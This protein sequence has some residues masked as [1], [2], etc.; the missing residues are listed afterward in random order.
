[1]TRNKNIQ[2]IDQKLNGLCFLPVSMCNIILVS[3]IYGL[4]AEKI[5][6]AC[7][8]VTLLCRFLKQDVIVY[9]FILNVHCTCIINYIDVVVYILFIFLFCYKYCHLKIKSGVYVTCYNCYYFTGFSLC[10]CGHLIH[11]NL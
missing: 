2:V 9:L 4:Q 3:V 6:I 11:R 10:S 5:L 1:M 8:S 7:K